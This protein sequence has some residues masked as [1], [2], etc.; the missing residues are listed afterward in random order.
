MISCEKKSIQPTRNRLPD[1][2]GGSGTE[3]MESVPLPR[4]LSSTTFR[5]PFVRTQR[6]PLCWHGA[7]CPWHRR[8]RCLFKHREIGRSPITG[9]NEFK[10]ELNALWTALKKLAASLMWRT[11]NAAATSAA[12]TVDCTERSGPLLRL[13]ESDAVVQPQVCQEQIAAGRN[14]SEQSGC[15]YCAG[16]GARSGNSRTSGCG[17]ETGTNC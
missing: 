8:G 14:E 4:N 16:A 6:V 11:A 7:Q 10:A 13:D 5:R 12:I 9:E 1:T 2:I 17:A 15:P 3:E